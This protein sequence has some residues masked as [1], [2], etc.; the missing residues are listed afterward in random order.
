M[1][2]IRFAYCSPLGISDTI[3]RQT[4]F[5]PAMVAGAIAKDFNTWCFARENLVFRRLFHRGHQVE[6]LPEQRILGE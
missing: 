1:Y 5:D 2:E 6:A 4:A 3:V